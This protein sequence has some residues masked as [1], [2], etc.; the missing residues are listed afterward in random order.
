MIT[1][2]AITRAN[3]SSVI[4]LQPREDQR[5]FV[6]SN[7]VS[8]AQA[9]V[10]PT[11]TPLAIISDGQ[12]VGFVLLGR[13]PETG[14]NWIIRFMV[15]QHQQGKG[16][17]RAGLLAAI[18]RLRVSEGHTRTRLSY[19]PGNTLAERLYRSVGFEATG[20]I[21]DGEIVMELRESS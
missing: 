3:L 4:D 7:V 6:A 11:W 16:Y 10:E 12:P 5:S 9:Y 20:D 1:L 2:E 17:G 13:E 18:D 19:V 14:Y 15:D 8:I 21:D